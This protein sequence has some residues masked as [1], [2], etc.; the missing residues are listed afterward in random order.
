MKG[1]KSMVQLTRSL[2]HFLWLY[3]KDLLA[4][5]MFGHTELY[6]EEIEQEYYKWLTTDE[7]K[8]WESEQ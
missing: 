5:L 4:P 7:Y 3:H 1:E 2:K 8:K 6:T